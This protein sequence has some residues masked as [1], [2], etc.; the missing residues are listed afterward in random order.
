MALICA[1]VNFCGQLGTLAKM[2]MQSRTFLHWPVGISLGAFSWLLIGMGG[3]SI[4]S[5]AIS[6]QVGLRAV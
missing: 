5:G 1:V 4:L 6:R 3:H 2:Q